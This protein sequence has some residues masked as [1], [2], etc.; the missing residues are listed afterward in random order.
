[1][2]AQNRVLYMDERF[3]LENLTGR[4]VCALWTPLT[5]FQLAPPVFLVA[6]RLMVRLPID[7]T[8]AARLIPLVCGI[9]SMLL[10]PLVARLY[11]QRRAVPIATA[12]FA[13]AEY[14]LYYSAEIKQDSCDV[15]LTLLA[16]LLAARST[17]TWI[18]ALFGAIGAWWSHPLVFVLAGVGVH[19]LVVAL[20]RKQWREAAS[21]SAMG[22]L[23]LA[24]FGACFAVS[25]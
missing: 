12:L 1:E 20:L 21:V 14:L 11:V 8:L 6:E 5:E 16:L 4:A 17:R 15:M 18:L 13:L 9:A 25:R 7:D 24:S 2:S 23:W 19:R 3:L 10:L 22:L